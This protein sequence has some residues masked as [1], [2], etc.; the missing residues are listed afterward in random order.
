MR[1][2]PLRAALAALLVAA[3]PL[4]SLVPVRTSSPLVAQESRSATTTAPSARA[5]RSGPVHGPE[6]G[7][8]V[9]AG[10]GNLDGT[11]IVERFIALAG[12]P[13][14]KIVVVPTAGG[15]RRPNGDLI[16]YDADQVLAAWKAR[17]LTNVH[18]L[19]TH[20]SKVADTDAF[21]A[22]LRDARGV[23]FNGGRQWN[24]VD[25]Y[26]G[27]RT[28]RAFHD[29]L[30]RGGVIGGSSAGA[31]IQGTYLVRGAV[32][33]AQVMMAPEP[34]HQDA[35]DFLRRSAIDQHVDARNRWND[36]APVL[37]RFPTY[38]GIGL[39]EGTAIVVRRDTFEVIGKARVAVHDPTGATP[40][41]PG[42]RFALLRAGD[43]YDMAARRILAGPRAL[44]VAAPFDT[45]PAAMDAIR[46]ADL[47][48]DL[49]VLAGDAMRG[50]EGG[51]ID[52]LR[53]SVWIAEQLRAI[54]LE[55][56]GDDGSYLQW[57]NIRRTRIGASS[58]VRIGTRDFALWRD[59]ATTANAPIDLSAP[60]VW[61]GDGRDTTI[62]V[63]GK[64]ALAQLVP[65]PPGGRQ[66][67]VNSAEYRY[68]RSAMQSLGFA[69]SRRGAVAVVLVA[70]S[71]ADIAWEGVANIAARGT[72]RVDDPSAP[73][74]PAGAATPIAQAQGQAQVPVFLVRR[75]E[76]TT[77]QAM[78]GQ[79]A[80]V[81]LHQESF[82]H[83]S[84]NIVGRVRGTDPARAHE[85]VL[86]SSHQD[87]DGVRYDVAGDS[88]WNG[89][90]DNGTTSVA[91]L[92]IARAFKRQPGARS[93][94][95][96]YHGAEERGL[97]GSN[98]HVRNPVVPLHDVVAVING[99]MLG[100]NHP[101]SAA[102]LGVQPPH[103][104]ST[105]L[106]E[107]A[108]AANRLT[109][110][111]ALDSLW[112]RPTHPEGWYFRSDHLP[113]AR[114]NVPALFF[115]SNLHPDYHTP[116]DEPRTIDY[117]KLTRMTQWLYVTGWLAAN[118][119]QRPG[120]DAGFR[121]ER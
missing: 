80:L 76:G 30:A 56:L 35:F 62:D 8:L 112:D 89:A 58:T 82:T 57:W 11:G 41:A 111:F 110:R 15:N 105:E 39:S 44:A 28:Y 22:V 55:P 78:A 108:V 95:F 116:R 27:T 18:M 103:R 20:D 3:S 85:H 120:V 47:R 75:S 64:V 53:A 72:Y 84:V 117:A 6:R 65:P 119:P 118:V 33:G 94:L 97:L 7:S 9:I 46:E 61:A 1:Q 114:A 74:R 107:L 101:D 29:V 24:I 52:E 21:A 45:V 99:D 66:T 25:S 121:L 43:R 91:L 106:V 49:T 67:S 34:E 69:L 68:A 51:T 38:L 102:L 70:D 81:R 5:A 71:T 14:A 54:G 104:N 32:A 2:F 37:E 77:L 90:D 12:G 73:A 93:A 19:H 23:W 48:R 42:A 17:G 50:R 59:I 40:P 63:R 98:Y 10:G 83:P 100:R 4:T 115:S 109:G 31:T 36:L 86:F 88:I 113:Y 60:T 13:S 16:S 87:H 79:Q 26:A 96:V 92:A